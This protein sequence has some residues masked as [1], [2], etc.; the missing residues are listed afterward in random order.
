MIKS[1]KKNIIF[2]FLTVIVVF[3]LDRL[4]KI[5]ILKLAEFESSLDIYVLPNL[6]FYLIW[7]KGISFGLLPFNDSFGYMALSF[8]ISF[9]IL[10][11]LIMVI[12]EENNFKKYSLLLIL[13]GALGNL[14][15]RIKYSAVP[16]FIDLHIGNIHWF[17]FNVADIFISLG[18]VCLIYAEIFFKKEE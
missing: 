10:I 2:N 4:S 18:V 15:D 6:N 7:N 5:Y 12:K 1:G 3:F 13:G 11:I 17:I 8:L 14:Y 9:L 16:D